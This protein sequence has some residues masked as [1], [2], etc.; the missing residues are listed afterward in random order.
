MA[1]SSK[2]ITHFT[3]PQGIGEIEAPDG[4]SEVEHKGGGC[5]DRIKL[6]L[7]IA[8]GR[9]SEIKF[10]ARACS[11]TIAACS[12]LVAMTSGISLTE[13]ELL[14]KEDMI[15]FLDGVPEKKHHSIELAI[16]GLKA[17]LKSYSS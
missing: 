3:N 1:F 4:M 8:Q 10:K 5:F 12:A 11:G 13:A 2:Y 15:S 6:T 16:E 17:A 7:Q 14:S 9:I